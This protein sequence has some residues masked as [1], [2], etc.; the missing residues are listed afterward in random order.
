ML[1]RCKY[2]VGHVGVMVQSGS[3]WGDVSTEW[4]MLGRCK[5]TV[6]RVGAM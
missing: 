2:T 6:D 3:C 1:G 5:Y 4:V